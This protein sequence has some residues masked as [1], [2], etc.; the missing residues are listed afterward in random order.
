MQDA[1]E[2]LCDTR[3]TCRILLYYSLSSMFW[4]WELGF[5]DRLSNHCSRLAAPIFTRIPAKF[6]VVDIHE[7]GRVL[8]M[9]KDKGVRIT[10]TLSAN[11]H[12]P[13]CSDADTLLVTKQQKTRRG[14][15]MTTMMTMTR[16]N[17]RRKLAKE[18]DEVQ[19]NKRSRISLSRGK[20]SSL[21]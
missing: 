21:L 19:G 17:P 4:K 1:R 11:H 15:R 8:W 6:E 14:R 18:A 5:Q 20:I 3:R 9:R 16:A 12:D 7:E 2:L 13:R 10:F